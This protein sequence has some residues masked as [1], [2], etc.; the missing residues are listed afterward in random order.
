MFEI[1]FFIRFLPASRPGS[2][3]PA[4]S[5]RF[6]AISRSLPGGSPFASRP[7]ITDFPVAFHPPLPSLL[8]PITIFPP[9]LPA[10]LSVSGHFHVQFPAQFPAVSARFS[11]V[12]RS[13]PGRPL[14]T[15]RRP[16]ILPCPLYS[17]P[18]PSSR[19]LSRPGSPF[20]VTSMSSF[21][22]S[23]QRFLLVSQ[24]FP[25]R[26]PAV[27]YGLSGGLS[28]SPALSTPLNRSLPS[29]SAPVQP[30]SERPYPVPDT[31]HSPLLLSTPLNR[32]L[33]SRSTPVQS[34]SERPYPVPDTSIRPYTSLL[35]S[36][37][38]FQ[39]TS[40]LFRCGISIFL[41]LFQVFWINLRIYRKQSTDTG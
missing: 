31:F 3:F 26:F 10:R 20:P 39:A 8:R 34:F 14:R 9:P 28:S 21:L 13:L 25:V 5:A 29:R 6:S 1:T 19:H 38:A 2:P 22:L 27:H 12:P 16:F 33:P 30:F 23:S 40:T 4:V 36:I 18:S 32:S 41:F 17:V 15:F 7:S 35:R 24:P 37:A 11:A